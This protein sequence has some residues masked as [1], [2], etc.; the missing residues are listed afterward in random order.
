MD[1]TLSALYLHMLFCFRK[2]DH[3]SKHFFQKVHSTRH[4][5]VSSGSGYGRG[6][7]RGE[8]GLS[9]SQH[10]IKWLLF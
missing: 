4:S 2:V 5:E 9:V 3:R 1:H 6:G 10:Q 8:E 7:W